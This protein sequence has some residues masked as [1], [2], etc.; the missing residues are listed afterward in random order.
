MF[1]DVNNLVGWNEGM[2]QEDMKKEEFNYSLD[3]F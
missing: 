3:Y 2:K 1:V